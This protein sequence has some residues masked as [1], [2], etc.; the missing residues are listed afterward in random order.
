MTANN[1]SPVD[2][3]NFALSKLGAGRILSL[4]ETSEKAI[5]MNLFYDHTRQVCLN[6]M[7]WQFARKRIALPALAETPAFEYSY[8]YALPSDFLRLFMVDMYYPDYNNSII[9]NQNPAPYCLESNR[10]LTNIEAP[11][12]IIYTADIT[13]VTQFTPLFCEALSLKLALEACEQITQSN[14]KKDALYAQYEAILKRVAMA[15]KTQLPPQQL[16]TGS[17]IDS[18]IR[19]M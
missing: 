9:I 16:P 14:T 13:D 10:I 5:I 19:G 17:F 2:I 1:L 3:A 4:S 8:Q 18:R 7:N 12:K 15:D 6:T 11:L